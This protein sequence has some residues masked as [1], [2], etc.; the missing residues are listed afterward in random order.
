[1]LRDENQKL[2][3]VNKDLAKKLEKML[4][5][6]EDAD[7]DLDN[8]RRALVVLQ[9]IVDLNPNMDNTNEDAGS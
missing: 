2:K 5:Y 7:A 3:K 8:M 1:M 9:G 6:I 4:Q